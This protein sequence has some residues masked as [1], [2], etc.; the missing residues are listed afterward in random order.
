MNPQTDPSIG[1]AW[2]GWWRPSPLPRR[3]RKLWAR[4]AGPGPYMDVWEAVRRHAVLKGGGDTT[5]MEAHRDP[6]TEA[7]RP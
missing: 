1:S 7:A 4:I 3:R 6:N 5:V 2:C